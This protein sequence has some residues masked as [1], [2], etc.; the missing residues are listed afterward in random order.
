MKAEVSITINGVAYGRTVPIRMLLVDF[1]RYEAGLTGTHVGCTFEG[2]CGA[3]TVH[4]DGNAIKACLMLAVQADGRNIT[5]VEGLAK[6]NELHPLQV[7]FNRHHALQCGFCTSG[8]LMSGL[9]LIGKTPELS[10]EKVRHGLVGNICRC[11]GYANIVDAI[12]S[13]AQQ[14]EHENEQ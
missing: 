1:I 3:C 5:T 13:V 7:A 8:M 6:G 11:A 12:L 2:V 14:E 10:E 4:L 9:D